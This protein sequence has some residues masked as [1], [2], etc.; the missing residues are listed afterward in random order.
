VID[1]VAITATPNSSS[2]TLALAARNSCNAFIS[3]AVAER[4]SV[5]SRCGTLV[6]PNC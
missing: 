1:F 2:D 5:A 6:D 4:Q 3:C